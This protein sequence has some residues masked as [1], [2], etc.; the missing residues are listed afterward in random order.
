MSFSL[1][2]LEAERDNKDLEKVE[3]FLSSLTPG[4]AAHNALVEIVKGLSS[5]Q[6]IV[7]ELVDERL[8]TTKAAEVLGVSRPHLYKLLDSGLI[9]WTAKS[10]NSSHRVIAFSDL[11]EY[12][13]SLEA[14]KRDR[15]EAIANF[16]R[17]ESQVV[18]GLAGLSDEAMKRLGQ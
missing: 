16:G 18:A 13:N 7:V 2:S 9:P 10:P 17:T 11:L 1:Q 4:S 15:A 8:T 5:G 3:K 12:V 6:Q 14:H